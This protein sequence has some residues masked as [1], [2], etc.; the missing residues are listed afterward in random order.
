MKALKITKWEETPLIETATVE[1]GENKGKIVKEIF[2]DAWE[3]GQ[4][5]L[6]YAVLAVKKP[7]AKLILQVAIRICNGIATRHCNKA[8]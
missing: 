8:L 6:D 2:C 5:V 4:P 1:T 7:L 3:Q